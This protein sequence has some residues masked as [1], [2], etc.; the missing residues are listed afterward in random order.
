MLFVHRPIDYS[1]TTASPSTQK[2]ASKGLSDMAK[3]SYHNIFHILDGRTVFN[4][5]KVLNV[6]YE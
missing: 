4:S 3:L 6:L 2:K 5:I 1:N